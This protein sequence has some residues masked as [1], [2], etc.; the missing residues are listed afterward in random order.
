[1]FAKNVGTVDRVL[2]IVLGVVLIGLFFMYPALG[3]WKWAA[4]VIGAVMLLTAF[5]S[6]C[7]IYTLLGMRTN[8]S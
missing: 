3:I 6:S 7:L 5:M 4:L 8:K 2:R 1:M